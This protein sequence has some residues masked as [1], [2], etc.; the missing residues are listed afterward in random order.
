MPGK[1]NSKALTIMGVPAIHRF[2]ATVLDPEPNP[3]QVYRWLRN[4]SIR[5]RKFE[6]QHTVTKVQLL[7]DVGLE[8]DDV[9]ALASPA[10]AEPA[11]TSS[12]AVR[13]NGARVNGHDARVNGHGAGHAAEAAPSPPHELR[14]GDQVMDE[15]AQLQQHEAAQRAARL[16]RIQEA[17][18]MN[19][20]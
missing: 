1:S 12:P 9:L 15:A 11:P 4:G 17:R 13:T 3:S 18:A 20:E 5:S 14:A 19:E 2:L 6:G 7:E 10:P 8:L 16:Q